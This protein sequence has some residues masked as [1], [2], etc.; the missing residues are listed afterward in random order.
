MISPKEIRQ[1]EETAWYADGDTIVRNE[2]NPSI[3]YAYGKSHV[4]THAYSDQSWWKDL[5]MYD[6]EKCL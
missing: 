1:G 3:A 4:F 6:S 5:L 2:H